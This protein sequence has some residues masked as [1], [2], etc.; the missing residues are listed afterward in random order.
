MPGQR[1]TVQPT[2]NAINV[3]KINVDAITTCWPATTNDTGIMVKD[4]S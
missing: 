2:I 3:I 1:I 4:D